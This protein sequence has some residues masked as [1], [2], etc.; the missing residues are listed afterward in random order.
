MK[1]LLSAA[2]L[3]ASL[4]AHPLGAQETVDRDMVARIRAEGF[5]DSHVMETLSW[6]SDVYGPRLTGSDNYRKAAEWARD[7]MTRWG[8]ADAHLEAW[9]DF[10]PAWSVERFSVEMVAPTYDRIVAYPS[11]WTPSTSGTVR[12]TPVRVDISSPADFDR[13]RGTLKGAIVMLGKP[14]RPRDPFKAPS[15]RFSDAEL[16]EMAAATDPGEP[17]DYA[18][19]EK[20]WYEIME[21]AGRTMDFL[22]DEGIAALLQPSRTDD[23]VLSVSGLGDYLH[24]RALFPAF[25]IS[26]EQYGR[27]SRLLDKEVPVTL[28]LSLTTHFDSTDTKGYDI[29]AEIPGTDPALEDQLV[30]LGG[31]FDSWHSG[32]GATD[33]G[34]GSAVAMEAV[35]ILERLGV[36]PRRTIRIGLW[37]GEEQDYYGSA[38]YVRNHFGDPMTGTATPA[39]AKVSA[40]FNPDNGS[41][42]IRG[43]YLQG[44]E[45]VRPI[46]RA[47]LAPFAD[48]GASTL[49][50]KNTGGTDHMSFHAVGIPAFQFIQDPL[51]YDTRRHHTNLDVYE[52]ASEEDLQQAAV[53]LATFVYQ[54]AIRDEML[55]RR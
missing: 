52:A 49:T 44:N 15:S 30:M 22:H 48:L 40:Y 38:G 12:G 41:G 23:E 25:V 29:V 31:H 35:R 50:V 42:R 3:A 36:R 7:R 45:R 54:A 5:Q 20:E 10:G 13:Y 55:P 8:L 16:A 27:I 32:T 26:K 19:E 51:D 17:R 11:A 14:S 6:I 2:L 4:V 46:F 24:P 47:W 18:S 28:E 43:V 39:A 53:I 1:R 37:G 34:A 33:N 21:N 9:G